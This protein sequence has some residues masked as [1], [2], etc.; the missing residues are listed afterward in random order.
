M[1]QIAFAFG[2][3]SSF[4]LDRR[5]A[6]LRS[7]A[8]ITFRLLLSFAAAVAAYAL[9]MLT[10]VELCPPNH[11]LAKLVYCAGLGLS[12]LLAICAGTL[13]AP[14][15]FAWFIILATSGLALSLPLGINLHAIGHGQLQLAYPLYLIVTLA[16]C[17]VAMLLMPWCRKAH[18]RH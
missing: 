5:L 9:A 10:T 4:C 7:W 3:T 16:G 14:V 12:T 15:R 17:V 8:K 11:P 13:T 2:A 18:G 1:L 6:R